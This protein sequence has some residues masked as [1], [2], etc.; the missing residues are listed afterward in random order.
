M[1]NELKGNIQC[2]NWWKHQYFEDSLKEIMI[3]HF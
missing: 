1:K 3:E 2:V